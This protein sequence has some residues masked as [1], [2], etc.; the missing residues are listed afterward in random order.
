[1]EENT[2]LLELIAE[3]SRKLG[4]EFYPDEIAGKAALVAEFPEDNEELPEDC[5]VTEE[6]LSEDSL[7]LCI[8]IT[9]FSGLDREQT[10]NVT[11]MTGRLN[12][13][14]RLG[15]FSAIEGA[16]FLNYTFVLDEE[17]P[18]IN[19]LASFFTS[20]D[21]LCGSAADARQQLLPLVKG[22]LTCQQLEEQG[23]YTDN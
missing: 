10:E 17:Q 9:V 1:M 16:L 13:F 14:M 22:E 2:A 3:Q 19:T 4:I 8:L 6:H 21:A 11:R 15:C 7:E 12:R 20:L 5:T 18:A 23:I